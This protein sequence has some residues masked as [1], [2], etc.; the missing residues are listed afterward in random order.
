MTE[1]M[2]WWLTAGFFLGEQ[3]RAGN[4]T[5][6]RLLNDLLSNYNK[7]ARPRMKPNQPVSVFVDLVLFQIEDLVR[8]TWAVCVWNISTEV[9]SAFF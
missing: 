5:E 1:T 2:T 3:Q 4:G 8:E 9:F 6:K 7:Y